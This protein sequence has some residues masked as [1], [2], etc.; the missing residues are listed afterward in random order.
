MLGFPTWQSLRAAWRPTVSTNKATPRCCSLFSRAHLLPERKRKVIPQLFIGEFTARV[1]CPGHVL[2]KAW[3]VC[4]SP[5]CSVCR[6]PSSSQTGGQT[7][8]ISGAWGWPGCL[9]GPALQTPSLQPRERPEVVCGEDK[10]PAGR[11]ESS[12]VRFVPPW[13]RAQGRGAGPACCHLSCQMWDMG[14][15]PK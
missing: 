3:A 1:A 13:G 15:A 5:P 4:L 7:R 11:A 6:V 14:S 8:G 2:Q 12:S 9:C 10:L